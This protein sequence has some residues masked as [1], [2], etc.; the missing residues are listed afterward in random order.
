MSVMVLDSKV[1]NYIRAGIER[2]AYN[3]TVNEWYFYRLHYMRDKDIE[4]ETLRLVRSLADLNEL[5][6]CG[7]YKDEF[8]RLSKF[9]KPTFTHKELEPL[10]FI[11]YVQCL[12]YNIEPEHFTLTPQQLEDY[13]LIKQIEIE[14]LSA[15]V[16]QLEG[17]KK[18]AWSTE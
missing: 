3:T 15:Y 6:Y 18:A 10:Q 16:G 4:T 5:S 1:F 13:N 12:I 11:K 7:K 17:Y 8:E 9:I 14:A 2:A